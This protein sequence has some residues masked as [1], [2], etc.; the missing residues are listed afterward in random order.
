MIDINIQ[1]IGFQIKNAYIIKKLLIFSGVFL[2]YA[3][4][5]NAITEPIKI[6]ILN[7][8]AINFTFIDNIIIIHWHSPLLIIISNISYI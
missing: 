6:Q 1:Y 4:S 2:L 3:K 7:K 5:M 8:D